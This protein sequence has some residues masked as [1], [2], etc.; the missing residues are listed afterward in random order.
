MKMIAEVTNDIIRI[1]NPDKETELLFNKILSYTDK[2]KAYQIKRMSNNPFTRNSAY[3][4][5]LQQEVKGSL[6]KKDSS[7]NLL[8]PS[9]FLH[10]VKNIDMYDK[11]H[12]TGVKISL[13]WNKKPHDLRDYQEEA[14]QLMKDNF[15]GLINFATGLGKTLVAIHIIR[16]CNKRALV[17]CP[18]ESIATQFYEQLVSAFG[19]NKV[20]FY[21]DGKK[22]LGDITV[23]IAASVNKDVDK[24]H[25][26]ELGLV[27][28]DEVHHVPANTFYAIAEGLSSVGKIFGLTATDFRSDGKD[29]F[30]TA[31]CGD[32]L[33]SK[34][35]K[36][37]VENSWLAA[38][39]FIV[40]EVD[41]T[42]ERQYQTDKLKNYRAHVLNCKEM[43]DRIKHD[44]KS[45]LDAGKSVLC[46]VD[47]VA[48]GKELSDELR[49]PFAT[50]SDKE[51]QEYVNQLNSGKIK[52]LIG[53]DG[54]VGEGT[55]TRKV[56][57][58]ILANFVASK[59]PVIQSIGRGLRKYDGKDKCIILDYIPTGSDMLSRHA[60]GRIDFYK[61]ITD[62]VKVI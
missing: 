25:N 49:V 11:R 22:K 58:L 27:I 24:F 31:G 57:V 54:K 26:H 12:D 3:F 39:Y 32:V 15:R 55:D 5:K 23:G 35:I 17:V 45:F 47:Q 36:W 59:G 7:G 61:E 62:K 44:M 48:H 53:T 50:G 1:I 41:T 52:G 29:I 6:F 46:L 8:I 38:P 9:G 20:G 2:S 33:I 40:R 4:K 30:I 43:K 51:S 13:P 19:K 34:D 10:L 37:G 18:S 28:I 16:R 42:S 56:E 60:W 14:V 21:G